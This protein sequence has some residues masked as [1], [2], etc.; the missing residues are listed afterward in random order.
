VAVKSLQRRLHLWFGFLLILLVAGLG[1]TAYQ[2]QKIHIITQVDN[3]LEKHLHLVIRAFR[4]AAVETQYRHEEF[5]TLPPSLRESGD[6]GT[7]QEEKNPTAPS[8]PEANRIQLPENVMRVF[9]DDAANLFGILGRNGSILT[10]SSPNAVAFRP[11]KQ[12]RFDMFIR[13]SMHGQWRVAYHF[14]E[15]GNFIW[16]ATNMS[17]AL[18]GLHRFLGMLVL[19]S[20]IILLIGIG[21][22]HLSIYPTL[23][24]VR[25]IRDTAKQIAEG[26][27]SERIPTEKMDTEFVP[28]ADVLNHTFSRL[29]DA[30]TRQKQF[31]ADA[32]HELRTPLAVIISEAQMA[33][34]RERSAEEYQETIRSCEESAQKMRR[35]FESLLEL[36]QLDSRSRASDMATVDLCGL[37]QES[38]DMLQQAAQDH[39]IHIFPDGKSLCVLC[40][41]EQLTRVFINLISNAITYSHPGGSVQI[42]AKKTHD[43]V[44]VTV[45]DSGVGIPPEALPHIFER[46][47]RASHSGPHDGHVGLG[48]SICKAIVEAHGGTI[49]AESILGRGTTMVVRLPSAA[50]AEAA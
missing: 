9:A 27:L 22:G 5:V 13:Y 41:P 14:T 15:L 34:R 39:Q 38:V 8:L 50:P 18:A 28:L 4:A 7:H 2:L 3:Q 24:S 30:L 40:Y 33:L 46:F 35:L 16:V 31:T 20:G 25:N 37:I 32:A 48:L 49:Q 23:K 12:T 36:A 45:A 26:T 47:Y 21:G 10:L 43:E 19:I 29:D 1:A 11:P 17:A 44:V 6:A 42:T